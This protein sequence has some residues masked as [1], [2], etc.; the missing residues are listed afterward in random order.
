MKPLLKKIY[1]A[2]PF[3]KPVFSVLRKLGIPE[4]IYKHLHFKGVID[5][6]VAGKSFKVFHHGYQI[7]NEIFWSGLTGGWEKVS[8]GLWIQLCQKSKCIF[9]VGANTGIYAL[10]AKTVNPNAPVHA[11]EPVRR[12][13]EK[14]DHNIK[15]NG[16]DIVA[17]EVAL[18]NYNGSATIYDSHEE[19]TLSVTVNSKPE[20]TG[21]H[22]HEVSI[23]TCRL[24]TYLPGGTKYFQR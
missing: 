12:V 17:N 3:K 4:T 9:D 7:E 24:D 11:F 5:V 16:F 2:A 8:M 10:V 15:L 18:S 22:L 6:P 23:K 14:L 20:T 13:K 19:H 1:Q 21:R